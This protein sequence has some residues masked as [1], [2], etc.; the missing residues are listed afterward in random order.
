MKRYLILS[1][2]IFLVAGCPVYQSQDTPVAATLV[3]HEQTR[4]KYWSYVPSYYKADRD[5]PLVITLHGTYG[6]ES[7]RLQIMEWKKLAEEKGFI[8]AAP[9]LRSVQGILPVNKKLWFND[10]KKDERTIL[11]VLEELSAKYNIDANSVLLSGFSAGG[12]PMYHAGLRN[13]EKFN[14]LVARAC[15]SDLKLFERIE[16]TDAARRIPVRIFWGKDD[17]KPIAD[18]SWQ[19]FRWLRQHGFRDVEREKTSGGHIRRPE[20]AYRYWRNRLPERH[21]R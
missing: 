14:M 20:L 13:P 19:A 15:N 6:F 21:R 17:L 3:R 5:W 2:L 12:Y 4:D 8:V 1:P 7:S 18:Q 10:L 16:L 9:A 11:A